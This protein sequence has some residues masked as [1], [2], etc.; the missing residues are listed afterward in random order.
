MVKSR[1]R[2]REV[3]IPMPR[4][5]ERDEVGAEESRG[6]QAGYRGEILL[7]IDLVEVER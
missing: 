4:Y 5:P 2:V 7:G 1:L 3:Y 6:V